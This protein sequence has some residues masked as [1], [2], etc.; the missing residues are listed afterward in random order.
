MSRWVLRLYPR[1]WR[2][3]YG[4]ELDELLEEAGVDLATIWD[5]FRGA[6]DAHLH[7]N[8]WSEGGTMADRPGRRWSILIPAA[9]LAFPTVFLIMLSV[10]GFGNG[11]V[12]PRL[13]GFFGNPVIEGI[14]VAGPCL[15]FFWS[16]A[17]STRISFPRGSQGLVA[18][19]RM[20]RAH[21]L[22]LVASAAMIAVY[23]TYYVLER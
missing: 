11:L 3:R 16:V 18:S 13:T 23:L 22:V 19:V 10:N 17:A 8:Q 2:E 15:A 9:L 5:L 1:R 6:L 20:T 7:R 4:D 12:F 14:T 21:G